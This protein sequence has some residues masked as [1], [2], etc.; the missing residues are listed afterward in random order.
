M[1]SKF[2]LL[3]LIVLTACGK[4]DYD[5][6]QEIKSPNGKYNF[7]LFARSEFRHS[8]FIVLK[9]ESSVNAKSITYNPN[10]NNMNI[11]Q[12]SVDLEMTKAVLK[13]EERRSDFATSPNIQLV[14][15]RF[16]VF[17]RGGKYYGLYELE[18]DKSVFNEFDPF[19]AWASQNIWAKKGTY[20]KGEIPK[21]EKSDYGIWVDKNIHNKIDEYIKKDK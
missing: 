2:L 1:N 17:S 21:D 14:K 11:A 16:L 9:L 6:I 13:N 7:C 18:M 3:F 5:L 10:S 4:D 12:S 19:G 15:N 8:D 20:Y